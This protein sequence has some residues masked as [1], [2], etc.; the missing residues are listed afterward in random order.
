MWFLEC[1]DVYGN[2]SDGGDFTEALGDQRYGNRAPASQAALR[3]QGEAEYA[4]RKVKK[5]IEESEAPPTGK[6]TIPLLQPHCHLTTYTWGKFRKVVL[7]HAGWNVK[8][9]AA[10][11]EEKKVSGEKRRGKVYFVYLIYTAPTRK[12][13][14]PTPDAPFSG[15]KRAG[16]VKLVTHTAA[17]TGEN[18]TT[19][20]KQGGDEEDSKMAAPVAKKA[21][22][23]DVTNVH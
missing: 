11:P 18:N 5:E 20:S 3:R 15:K 14:Q 9:R 12:K 13:S 6:T 19:A 21:K 4:F 23:S 1:F 22:L 10:T 17:A 2:S 7:E 8:R 16:P